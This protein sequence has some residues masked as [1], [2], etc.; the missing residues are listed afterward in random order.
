MYTCVRMLASAFYSL[1]YCFLVRKR[2]QVLFHQWYHRMCSPWPQASWLHQLALFSFS[3]PPLLDLLPCII[4]LIV[5]RWN[6]L[7][8]FIAYIVC[9]PDSLLTWG[10]QGITAH[11]L[12]CAP[13]AGCLWGDGKT[14]GSHRTK[15]Y[16]LG[17]CIHTHTLP[18]TP[19]PP[20]T[21]LDKQYQWNESSVLFWR[22]PQKRHPHNIFYPECHG[23]WGKAWGRGGDQGGWRKRCQ[24]C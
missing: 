1:C 24:L 4:G 20:H 21:P 15:D 22:W 8:L 18:P 12:H 13:S 19:P 2:K 16:C 23:P 10:R 17:R 6:L 14:T 7:V 9:P 3:L 5:M 11:L